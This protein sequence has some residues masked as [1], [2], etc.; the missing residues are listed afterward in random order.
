MRREPLL[1]PLP[2]ST[3]DSQA[4]APCPLL[5]HPGK[6]LVNFDKEILQ[7]MREAKY[8]ARLG[9]E[10][11]ESTRM[12][13]LQEEKFRHYHAQLSHALQVLRLRRPLWLAGCCG[14]PPFLLAA[15]P[16][17]YTHHPLDGPSPDALCRS[18]SV[19]LLRWSPAC[20]PCCGPTWRTCTT[21]WP[22]ACWC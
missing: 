16:H 12:V 4:T 22:L 10:V 18:W 14:M 5:P 15:C 20:T 19:C 2:Q 21:R 13:L 7:L 9:L 1:P 6:L 17:A 11:P 8:M 3:A